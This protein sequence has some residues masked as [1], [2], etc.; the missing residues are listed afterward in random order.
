MQHLQ[1]YSCMQPYLGLDGVEFH[2]VLVCE[3]RLEGR[4]PQ[5]IQWQRLHRVS[6]YLNDRS[7]VLIKRQST[8]ASLVVCC[9]CCSQ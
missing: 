8:Q 3:Q 5:R 9:S 2:K 7:E 4:L 1:P 6:D